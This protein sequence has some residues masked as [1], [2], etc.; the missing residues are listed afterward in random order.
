MEL[1]SAYPAFRAQVKALIHVGERRWDVRLANG[2]TVK[3]PAERAGKGVERLLA[4]DAETRSCR[5]TS[6]PSTCG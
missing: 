3:L 6:L 4:M 2:V 1:L 5:A